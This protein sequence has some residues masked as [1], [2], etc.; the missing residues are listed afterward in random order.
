MLGENP[1]GWVPGALQITRPRLEFEFYR[2]SSP[3]R[4]R[5]NEAGNI[6]SSGTL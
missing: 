5:R 1:P 2:P 4:T 6:L 3:R